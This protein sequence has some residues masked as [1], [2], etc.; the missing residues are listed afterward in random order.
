MLTIFLQK[1]TL[2]IN[3]IGTSPKSQSAVEQTEE[4]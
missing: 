4:F 3:I 2:K 1:V